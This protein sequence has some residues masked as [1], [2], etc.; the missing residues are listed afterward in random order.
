MGSSPDTLFT[1]GDKD[2]RSVSD[3]KQCIL[4][5]GSRNNIH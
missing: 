2:L 3:E 5:N 1:F 4:S